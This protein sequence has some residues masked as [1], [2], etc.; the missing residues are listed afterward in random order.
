MALIFIAWG[1]AH[2]PRELPRRRSRHR[3]ASD[4]IADTP[5]RRYSER[6]G[7]CRCL[8]PSSSR[9]GPGSRRLWP[10]VEHPVHDHHRK[11]PSTTAHHAS[12]T[13]PSARCESMRRS[14]T[15]C[16]A[17]HASHVESGLQRWRRSSITWREDRQVREPVLRAVFTTSNVRASSGHATRDHAAAAESR[18]GPH[19]AGSMRSAI[20]YCSDEAASP[21]RSRSSPAL[22]ILR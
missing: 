8:A 4:F 7:C 15:R 12:L 17:M 21:F 20:A 6:A 22:W 13:Q 2:V 19:A 1:P 11:H 10:H 3:Y 5:Y 18:V 16:D 14:T 9:V